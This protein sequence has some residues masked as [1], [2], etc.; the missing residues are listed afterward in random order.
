[1]YGASGAVSPAFRGFGS[2]WALFFCSV[3]FRLWLC[4]L[5][6]YSLLLCLSCLYVCLLLLILAGLFS[7][8]GQHTHRY[9]LHFVNN[10]LLLYIIVTIITILC[11]YIYIYIL[12]ITTALHLIWHTTAVMLSFSRAS[13]MS[14]VERPEVFRFW[15]WDRGDFRALTQSSVR[16][17]IINSKGWNS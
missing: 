7:K 12:Y 9:V 2:W 14:D 16:F 11:V 5:L 13:F 10:T 15:S 17:L 8:H 1:M 6:L 3:V 4:C